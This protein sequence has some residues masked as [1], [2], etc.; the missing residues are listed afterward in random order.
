MAIARVAEARAAYDIQEAAGP[1]A[2]RL[3]ASGTCSRTPADLSVTGRDKIGGNYRAGASLVSYEIDFWGRVKSLSE[4]ALNQF[5]ATDEARRAFELG[6]VAQLA[7]AY[8]LAAGARR[9]HRAGPEA[10]VTREN[11]SASWPGAPRWAAAPTSNC[12]RWNPL[13]LN[14]RGEL[15][16]LE[17]RA[18]RTTPCCCSSPVMPPP[19]AAARAARQ[20]GAWKT[21]LPP[22]CPPSSSPAGPTSAPPKSA[23]RRQPGQHPRGP[24][25]FLPTSPSPASAAPPAPSWTALPGRRQRLELHP[26]AAPAPLRRRPQPRQPQPRRSPPA[27]RRGR[28]RGPAIRPPSG[29]SDA[30]AARHWLAEQVRAQQGLVA[31]GTTAPGWPPCASGAA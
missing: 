13:L 14:T 26:G 24:R 22:A 6:L 30:L 11:P 23:S 19:P 5:L 28:L 18:P 3:G 15:A 29:V 25:A 9:A 16:A 31:T 20:A 21:P 17:R 12:A 4:T 1:P 7:N 2:V 27:G 10:L 8:L